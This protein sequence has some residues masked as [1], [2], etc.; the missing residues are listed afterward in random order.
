M[1]AV[2]PVKDLAD[3]QKFALMK[4]NYL[5][6]KKLINESIVKTQNKRKNNKTHSSFLAR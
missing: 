5:I 3:D 2:K 1:S 6:S 4:V